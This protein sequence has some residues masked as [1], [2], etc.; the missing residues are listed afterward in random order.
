M[1]LDLE[2]IIII[3]CLLGIPAVGVWIYSLN[4]GLE[5]ARVAMGS[6]TKLLR[7][8]HATHEQINKTKR[9]NNDVNISSP[10]VFFEKR[11]VASQGGGDGFIKAEQMRLKFDETSVRRA[12]AGKVIGKDTEAKVQ[13][14][15]ESGR[16]PLLLSRSFINAFIV[17]C[18][19]P[20]PVWRLRSLKITNK[21]FKEAKKAAP[22]GLELLDNWFVDTMAFARRSPTALKKK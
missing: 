21:D 18:E 16:K 14:F 15:E 19:S 2:K 3:L 9:A 7:E 11:L 13:F 4:Q 5:D 17:N 20:A 8:I 22:K 10:S 1:K 6:R 12:G